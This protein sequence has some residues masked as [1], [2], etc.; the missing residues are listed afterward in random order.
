MIKLTCL[1]Y[2]SLDGQTPEVGNP[3]SSCV[4]YQTNASLRRLMSLL[5]GAPKTGVKAAWASTKRSF[6]PSGLVMALTA[7][8][9]F[10]RRGR[11]GGS[12]VVSAGTEQW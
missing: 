11:W 5:F 7:R 2:G 1:I 9:T 12:A 3:I 8:A 10:Q 4:R 6:A